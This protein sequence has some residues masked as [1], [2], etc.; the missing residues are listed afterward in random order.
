MRGPLGAA[1]WFRR[2]RGPGTQ[3]G[4]VGA[5]GVGEHERVEAVVLVAGR[6]VAAAQVLDLVRADH[7]DGDAR[8]EQGL[9][10]RPIGAF[11]RDLAAARPPEHGDQFGQSGRA[12]L[13]A[14][15]D[16]LAAAGIDDRR[17][18]VITG[19]VQPAGHA[20]GWLVGQCGVHGGAGRLHVSLLAASPSGEAPSCGAGGSGTWL[21][22]RSLI[23]AQRR[24]ALST[25]CTSRATARPGRSHLGHQPRRASR[26]MTWRHLGR[27]TNPSE[28]SDT[29]MVHQ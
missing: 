2:C 1:R 7:H 18:M 25:V 13:D 26:A 3:S 9:D 12:V 14:V 23:G 22:V 20:V 29:R 19:P 4:P 27:I 11:D 6:A 21:P 24:S 16:L 17:G 5:H 15:P 8:A 28:I 10:H